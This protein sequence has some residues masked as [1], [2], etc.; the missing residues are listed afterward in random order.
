[1]RDGHTRR[2]TG[3]VEMV[4]ADDLLTQL[5]EYLAGLFEAGA[6]VVDP[7]AGT[8]DTAVV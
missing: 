6:G 5:V 2:E 8:A 4:V 3:S 1:M 7:G